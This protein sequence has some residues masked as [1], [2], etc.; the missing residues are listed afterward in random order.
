MKHIISPLPYDKKALEPTMSDKTL[1]FHHDKHYQAYINNLNTLIEGT[2]YEELN[3]T[4]II[5]SAPAGAIYNNAGQ[6]YNH[7]MFFDSLSANPH[8]EP[9]GAL[10]LAINENFGSFEKF[11]EQFENAAK[12]LFGSGWV[13]LANDC[14]NKLEIIP[15]SNAGNPI[16]LG[17]HPIMC[18]DVWEHAYYLDY[19]N[20]RPDFIKSFWNVFDWQYAQRR[21]QRI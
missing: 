11:K 3:L 6:V 13:F 9:D 1:E 16:T 21:F 18:I 19:Q 2:E 8:K 15:M 10:A 20:R 17:K 4:Q 12:S 5:S 7:Q 14:Q